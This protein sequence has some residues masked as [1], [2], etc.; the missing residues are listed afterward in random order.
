MH[1]HLLYRAFA[2]KQ[3]DSLCLK[4]VQ[5]RLR[6]GAKRPFAIL[7]QGPFSLLLAPLC[8]WEDALMGSGESLHLTEMHCK[9]FLQEGM[10]EMSQCRQD[11]TSSTT[12]Y[13]SC[14]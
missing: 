9:A 11:L 6:R 5:N 14:H 13:E 3:Q 7:Y 8:W 4:E 2:V 10:A 1:I 12:E